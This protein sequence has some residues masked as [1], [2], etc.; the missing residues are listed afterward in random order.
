VSVWARRAA[1]SLLASLLSVSSAAGEPGTPDAPP[2]SE[3]RTDSVE[4][5]SARAAPPSPAGLRIGKIEI[6]T[7]NIFDPS[8]G[9]IS[10]PIISVAN[11]LHMKTRSSTVRSHLLFARGERWDPERGD[12]AARNLRN[13]QFLVPERIDPVIEGDSL[14][15]IVETRDLWSTL[16]DFNLERGGGETVGAF[17]F[18]ERNLFG[19][20]KELSL[21]YSEDPT[22][23]SR[24]LFLHDPAIGGGRARLRLGTAT[25]SGG[26]RNEF[27]IG[28]PFYALDATSSWMAEGDR[29]TSVARLFESGSEVA[30]LDRRVENLKFTAGHGGRVGGTVRRVTLAFH[31]FNRRLGPTVLDPGAPPDFG[32]DEDN[33]R[34]RRLSGA[35]RL[36]R[37]EF[38][39]RSFVNE[40]GPVED[41]DVG[42]S[43]LMELGY[44]PQFLGGSENEAFVR[45]GIE[46]GA[47]H[48]LGFGRLRVNM[49]SRVRRSPTEILRRVD[50]RWTTQWSP[51]HTTVVALLGIEGSRVPRDFQIVFGGLNGL[52]AYGVHALS[53]RRAWRLNLEDRW[54]LP[55]DIGDLLRVGAAGFY[56]GARAWGP[57][58]GG[59]EWFHSLGFGLRMSVPRF[60]PSQVLRFDVAWPVSPTRDDR[61]DP[62]VSFGSTQA[63]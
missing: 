18:T 61:R 42:Q 60:A 35:V 55:V 57:G 37:P 25:G 27:L 1:A 19:F 58:S 12:E 16:L 50:G 13:L 26:A 11:A 21:G 52:R 48:R 43:A 7:R 2:R 54:G 32:G 53:G 33:L 3:A 31:L 41:F 4:A 36:W 39:Q 28:V 20:G 17:S 56:D 38:I 8:P 44:S 47:H 23:V 22:G 24:Q 63:F 10:G 14:R 34:I 59:S 46:A 51:R 40:M 45:F 6:V 62:V 9:S 30:H 5:P 29:S 15:V 49:E